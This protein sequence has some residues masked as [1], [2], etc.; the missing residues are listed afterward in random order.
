VDR[1]FAFAIEHVPT[2]A[3]LFLGTIY[4]PG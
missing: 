1:P 4:E 3:L 2:G